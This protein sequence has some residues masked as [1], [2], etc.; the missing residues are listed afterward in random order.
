[1]RRRYLRQD[2]RRKES[3]KKAYYFRDKDDVNDDQERE[4]ENELFEE[5]FFYN[6]E[7]EN[8]L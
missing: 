5:K 4:Y 2:S 3:L 8:D 7:I 6:K 1:M